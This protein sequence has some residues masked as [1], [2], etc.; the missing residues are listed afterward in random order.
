M[1][2][3]WNM[4]YFSLS[5]YASVMALVLVFTLWFIH[6]IFKPQQIVCYLAMGMAIMAFSLGKHNSLTYVNKIQPDRSQQKAEL[7]AKIAAEQ[8]A[9]LDQRGEQVAQIRFA[10]DAEDEFLDRAGLDDEDLENLDNIREELTPDWKREKKKRSASTE[11][12]EGEG[13]D[14]AAIEESAETEPIVMLEADLMRANHFDYWNLQISKWCMGLGLLIILYDYIR[15]HNRY[16]S[17]Y[18]PLKIPSALANLVTPYP[19]VVDR[20]SKP[21]RSVPDELVW[22]TKRGDP[23]VYF[24]SNSANTKEVDEALVS[25]FG[26]KKNSLQIIKTGT[27]AFTDNFAFESWWFGRSSVIVESKE[28]SESMI[29]SFLDLL[30]GRSSTRARVRQTAHLVWDLDSPIPNE[31]KNRLEQLAARTGFSLLLCKNYE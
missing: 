13:M 2:F 7:E 22:L 28:R 27:S 20:S 1:P 23:F 31:I 15:R 18:F 12:S 10:E 30:E 4:D 26:K 21:R 16:E 24:S 14:T 5:G 9:V 19:S 29:G 6:F 11:G 25:F 17:A 8:Q 3:E